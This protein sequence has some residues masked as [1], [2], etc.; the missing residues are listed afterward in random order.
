M[1]Q[2]A[3]QWSVTHGQETHKP[4]IVSGRRQYPQMVKAFYVVL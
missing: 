1:Q 2:S 4:S 3:G